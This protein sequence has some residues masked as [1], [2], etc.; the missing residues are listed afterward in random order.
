MAPSTGSSGIVGSSAM[1]P[2]MRISPRHRGTPVMRQHN[3]VDPTDQPNPEPKEPPCPWCPYTGSL[4]HVL[5]HMESQL[6]PRWYGVELSPP[7]VGGVF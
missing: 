3:H 7:I 6:H 2:M 5:L 1:M 4:K